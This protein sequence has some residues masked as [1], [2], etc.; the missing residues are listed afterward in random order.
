MA[1]TSAVGALEHSELGRGQRRIRDKMRSH[2]CGDVRRGL[3]PANRRAAPNHL[4]VPWPE[5]DRQVLT[6]RLVRNDRVA[7][8]GIIAVKCIVHQFAEE[9][10]YGHTALTGKRPEP[11]VRLQIDPGG[12][13]FSV[14]H[15]VQRSTHSS[16]LV[17]QV[18]A[19]LS[20]HPS[21]RAPLHAT[22]AIVDICRFP[23]LSELVCRITELVP[24]KVN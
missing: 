14:P 19:S 4:D 6:P 12:E 22:V 20:C 3:H 16:D 5:P 18:D 8:V 9:A 24:R 10:S 15:C 13:M 1:D 17:T 23:Q 2:E 21:P 11:L 7:C